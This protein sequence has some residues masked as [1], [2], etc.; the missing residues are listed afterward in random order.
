MIDPWFVLKTKILRGGWRVEEINIGG[1]SKYWKVYRRRD[2][3]YVYPKT[4]KMFFD[5]PTALL[6]IGQ[7][8][9]S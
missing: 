1:K 7:Q 4:N 9:L 8:D 3:G 6:Y 2:D 5:R